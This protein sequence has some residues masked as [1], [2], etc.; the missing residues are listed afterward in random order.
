MDLFAK[1]DGYKVQSTEE[2]KYN[3]QKVQTST[4]F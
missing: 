2:M 3:V 1:E 4:D